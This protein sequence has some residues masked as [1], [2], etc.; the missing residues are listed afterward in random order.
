MCVFY[1]SWLGCC[2][3]ARHCEIILCISSY[4]TNE[5]EGNNSCMLCSIQPYRPLPHSLIE[6]KKKQGSMMRFME[7]FLNLWKYILCSNLGESAPTFFYARLILRVSQSSL[8]VWERPV[9]H[10]SIRHCLL[11][12]SGSAFTVVTDHQVLM[13]IFGSSQFKAA[14]C[15]EWWGLQYLHG[16]DYKI[17]HGPRRENSPADY[18]SVHPLVDQHEMSSVAQEFINFTGTQAT[19]KL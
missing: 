19:L 3:N 17:V 9:S 16:Y 6:K 5:Y 4:F 10:P 13:T 7:V 18:I 2:D 8:E 1:C 14:M 11:F 12:I 15:S